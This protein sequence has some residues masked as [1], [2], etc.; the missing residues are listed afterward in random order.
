MAV[1]DSIRN[2]GGQRMNIYQSFSPRAQL[3]N[4]VFIWILYYVEVEDERTF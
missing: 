3:K 1:V 4:K 2:A